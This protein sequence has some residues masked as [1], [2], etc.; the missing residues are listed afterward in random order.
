MDDPRVLSLLQELG[1]RHIGW[2]I[3]PRDWEEGRTME[4]LVTRVVAGAG[5]RDEAVV[6]LHGWPDVTAE[7]LPGIIEGLRAEQADL[8]DVG[9]LS[10]GARAISHR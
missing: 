1:Y 4:E 3:D 8:I 6:L 10:A 2:D 9:A 5:G 7:G